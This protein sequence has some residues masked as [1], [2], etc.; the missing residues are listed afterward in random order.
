MPFRSIVGNRA[1]PSINQPSRSVGEA[2]TPFFA[3]CTVDRSAYKL[4]HGRVL[5]DARFGLFAISTDAGSG[6]ILTCSERGYS[7]GYGASNGYSN[8]GYGAS[9]GYGSGGYGGGAGGGDRMSNLGAN[10]QKQ[11]W[12]ESFCDN[13]RRG[14]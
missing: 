7:S 2:S 6:L 5:K 8:G 11:H 3:V 10:L 14:S 9:G 13:N 4:S 1:V 12:G